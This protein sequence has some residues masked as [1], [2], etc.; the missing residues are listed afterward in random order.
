MVSVIAVDA[1]GVLAFVIVGRLTRADY[2]GVLLPPIRE[3]IANGEEIRVLA[4]LEG[5]Q[6][7]EA[8]GLLERAIGAPRPRR[9][10]RTPADMRTFSMRRVVH[11]EG[12]SMNGAASRKAVEP[13]AERAVGNV[14]SVVLLVAV[15][16]Q[17]IRG[18][19][20]SPYAQ[21]LLAAGLV[22]VAVLALGWLGA[23]HGPR[24]GTVGRPD[25]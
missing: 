17:L 24:A 11:G 18:E 1:P 10:S 6:G 25:S 4:V 21:L 8:G 23:R 13:A 14:L 16:V 9:G 22:W 20:A 7:L 15:V 12:Q 5:F 2:R 3:V 19:T